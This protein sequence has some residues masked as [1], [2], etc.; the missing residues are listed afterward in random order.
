[1]SLCTWAS[2]SQTPSLL[3]R[4]GA[5]Q[6]DRHWGTT[7]A[8]LTTRECGLQQL[9]CAWVPSCKAAS[10]G[11]PVHGRNCLRHIMEVRWQEKVTNT[12]TAKAATRA[13]ASTS[14]AH[15]RW[16]DPQRSAVWQTDAG[17]TDYRQM[18]IP[19]QR[20]MKETSALGRTTWRQV[21]CKSFFDFEETLA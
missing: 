4:V 10:L 6:A 21:G 9:R 12:T 2:P 15:G 14:D 5:Q 20:C 11:P 8:R 19:L 17:K 18:T 7:M 3:T 13:L 16:S 1:M